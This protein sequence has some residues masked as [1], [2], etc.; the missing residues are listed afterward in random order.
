VGPWRGFKFQLLRGPQN[1]HGQS[2]NVQSSRMCHCCL[3]RV[4][5]RYCNCK[6]GVRILHL[7]YVAGNGG[8][9]V[10]PLQVYVITEDESIAIS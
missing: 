7:S 6:L 9:A 3:S 5:R 1:C 8:A 10:P 2:C 4:L